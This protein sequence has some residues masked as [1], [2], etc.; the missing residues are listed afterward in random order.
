MNQIFTQNLTIELAPSHIF[1]AQISSLS[2]CVLILVWNF[3]RYPR[4]W[5]RFGF[6]FSWF[7]LCFYS[8]PSILYGGHLYA[9]L[10]SWP[11]F[12]LTTNVIPFCL[13]LWIWV[14]SYKLA[15]VPCVPL[16]K[17]YLFGG[18]Q[19]I[20]LGVVFLAVLGGF[21]YA[22][23]WACTGLWALI[24]DPDSVLLA[25]EV[26]M[27]FN[28]SPWASRL[29]GFYVSVLGPL[30]CFVAICG[31]VY[32]LRLR[33]YLKALMSII[34]LC[35]VIFLLLIGGVKGVLLGAGIFVASAILS[36]S[37][38][39][40]QRLFASSVCLV[41]FA[42]MVL[43]FGVLRDQG[44]KEGRN[45][46]YDIVGCTQYFGA[47]ERV[48][49]LLGTAAMREEGGLGLSVAQ[50]ESL[51]EQVGDKEESRLHEAPH[52]VQASELHTP[53]VSED[54]FFRWIKPLWSRLF[55]VPMQV[56]SWH[57]FYVEDNI[58]HGWLV[59]PFFNRLIGD[60]SNLAEL[61]YS[62]YGVLYSSGDVTST[63]TAPTTFIYSYSAHLGWVGIT[64]S[65]ALLIAMDVL[66]IILLR[67][68][69]SVQLAGVTGFFAALGVSL[70]SSDFFT[71][72]FSHG[73]FLGFCLFW[74]LE[75]LDAKIPTK[76]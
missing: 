73:G 18:K 61:V 67:T 42:G 39:L 51:K 7:F 70:V 56:A 20:F 50:L 9:S 37:I 6:C 36:L 52:L 1:L 33:K 63:S 19:G 22:V 27:K 71:V 64:L 43:L 65:L 66:S 62:K 14:S 41:F 15:E 2:I 26:S 30:L 45:T 10:P 32:S 38:P 28:G 12:F 58:A 24:F 76:Q 25:R 5:S 47:H 8:L 75:K 60:G 13:S 29:Y 17:V 49:R 3:L 40:S 16:N 74:L 4:V 35:M 69:N 44:Q 23:P 68:R 59:I 46:Q 55:V 21:F 57:Y 11:Q 53:E 72:M 48:L 31:V 34:F 54:S